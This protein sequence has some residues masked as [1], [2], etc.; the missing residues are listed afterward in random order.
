MNNGVKA[1]QEIGIVR[2]RWS[3]TVDRLNREQGINLDAVLTRARLDYHPPSVADRER[4][5]TAT[6][7]WRS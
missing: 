4:L 6:N 1:L 5:F 3:R 7:S 2:G